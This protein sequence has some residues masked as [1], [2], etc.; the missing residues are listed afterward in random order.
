MQE[1]VEEF[2]IIP[3][4][5]QLFGDENLADDNRYW[6]VIERAFPSL[7]FWYEFHPGER[8]DPDDIEEGEELTDESY[9]DFSLGNDGFPQ[10]MILYF[11][12]YSVLHLD[13]DEYCDETYYEKYGFRINSRA[14]SEL[15]NILEWSK[16]RII[17][18]ESERFYARVV[19]YSTLRTIKKTITQTTS[20]MI[21]LITVYI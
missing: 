3:K 10:S 1:K 5:E 14:V 7:K 19:E 15:R 17:T 21:A 8:N 4:L 18:D 6:R 9:Y 16:N 11:V 2:I 12:M 13:E 20:T